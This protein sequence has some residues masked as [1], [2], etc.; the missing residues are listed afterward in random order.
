M[1]IEN[2]VSNA[3]VGFRYVL[4]SLPSRPTCD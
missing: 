2:I 3:L 1:G 4:R